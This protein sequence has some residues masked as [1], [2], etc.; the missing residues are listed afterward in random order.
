[1][2]EFNFHKILH[3]EIEYLTII[4]MKMMFHINTENYTYVIM[5]ITMIL[6]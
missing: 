2:I 6:H 4:F 3:Y 1:M 5:Y